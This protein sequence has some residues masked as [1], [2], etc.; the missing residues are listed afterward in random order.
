MA[1]VAAAREKKNKNNNGLIYGTGT[2]SY[3]I[4][5]S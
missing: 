3:E 5:E 2:K 1:Y 4:L